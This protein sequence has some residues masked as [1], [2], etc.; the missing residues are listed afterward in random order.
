M[1]TPV[2]QMRPGEI[3]RWRFVGGTAQ[4]SA[5]LE[6][7]FD[8]RIK[9][10]RQIA[11]DGVQFAWQNYDRQ[12]LRDTTGTFSNFKLS[13]GNRVDFL[14]KAPD[15]PGAYAV[16][17][18]VFTDE[19]SEIGEEFFNI[20][21][22]TIADRVPPTA[23]PMDR[24]PVDRNGNP[25]LFTIQVAGAANPMEFPV[26]EATDP[27]CRTNPKPARCWPGTPYYL[28]DLADPGTP[29]TK[30][31][32][33]ID[34]QITRQPNSFWINDS[35]YQACCAGVTMTL[36]RTENWVVANK[37]GKNNTSLLPH[38]FHIHT[39]PFQVIRNAD[40][41]FE[42]P[43][44]WQDTISLPTPGPPKDR[45]V[46]P[47]WDQKDAEVKCPVA[48]RAENATWNGQWTT[49]IP[50]VLSVCGCTVKSDDVAIRHRFDDYTGGYVIHC[51]FLGHE[52]RGMMWNVQTVCPGAGNKYGQTQ[53]GGGADNCGVTR[54]GLPQC[55]Q[56]CPPAEHSH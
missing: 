12:P 39:N 8:Q 55:P 30:L 34:G 50:N 21:D 17:S 15:Q 41:T 5:Q 7:G 35:Q 10:V 52:D 18:R 4:A 19:I 1:A 9:D 23:V 28:R 38:P 44:I 2:I 6:I 24:V 13:P 49:T 53:A 46:G 33:K 40:R 22:D 29:P 14:I 25:L 16:N 36:G 26:T 31:D 27:A 54:Q 43:Y 20:D 48:C 3:Q 45:P 32:F 56:Q 11:Q 47:I 51:H 42:P 37:L